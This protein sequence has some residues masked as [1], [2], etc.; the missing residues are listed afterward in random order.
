[1]NRTE[2]GMLDDEKGRKIGVEIEVES[3]KMRRVGWGVEDRLGAAILPRH[4]ASE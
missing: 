3:K 1:M 4:G 2:R